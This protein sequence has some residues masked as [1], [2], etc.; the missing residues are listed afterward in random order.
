ML[1]DALD[2]ADPSR[3]SFNHGESN[4]PVELD[5][6]RRLEREKLT[7]QPQHVR[8]VRRG[9][10]RGHGMTGRDRRLHVV[11][12][13]AL[14]GRGAIQVAQPLGDQ[15]LVPASAIL[16]REKEEIAGLVHSRR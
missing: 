2:G 1:L 3:G 13:H 7:V 11:R 10:V 4:G 12:R 8:P 14:T 16:L 15:A 6:G 5:H 9:L